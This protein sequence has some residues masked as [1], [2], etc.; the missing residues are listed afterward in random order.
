MKLAG[1][2]GRRSRGIA[3]LCVNGNGGCDGKRVIRLRRGEINIRGF[4]RKRIGGPD[5]GG[6]QGVSSI[7]LQESDISHSFYPPPPLIFVMAEVL[8]KHNHRGKL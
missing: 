4:C 8:Q 7:F 3:G 1:P 2:E 5:A 6:M